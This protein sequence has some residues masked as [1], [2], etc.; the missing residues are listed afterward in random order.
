M[1]RSYRK[2]RNKKIKKKIQKTMKIG[3]YMYSVILKTRKKKL[4]L[5]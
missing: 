4:T 3:N 1:S 2:I 5:N